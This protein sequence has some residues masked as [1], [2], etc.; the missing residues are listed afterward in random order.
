MR[1]ELI[2]L[3]LVALLLISAGDPGVE[4][5]EVV[6]EGE[7]AIEEHRGA[8]I[9]G[10]ATVTVPPDAE[11]RGPVYVIGGELRIEGAV[12]GNVTQLAGRLVV[13]DGGRIDGELE[14]VAGTREVSDAATVGERTSVEVVPAERGPVARYLPAALATLALALAGAGLSRSR[15]A[16]LDNVGAAAREHPAICLTVGGLLSV[17]LL[18]VFVFMAFTLLLIPVSLLGLL[19]G[20]LTIAYGVIA[21][22]HLVGQYLGERLAVRRRGAATGAGVVAVAVLLE[23]LGFVPV[24]GDLVGIGVLLTGLGAV[25]LTY[26]GLARFEPVAPPA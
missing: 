1:L 16:L 18:S 14:H 6:M 17:T 24:V 10:D 22:G 23:L 15:P 26:Y 8:L 9:L 2:P 11:I 19:A 3:L 25:V 5:A 20:A 12:G 21:L 7:H 13:E 4:T